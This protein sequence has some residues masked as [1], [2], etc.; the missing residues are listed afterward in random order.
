MFSYAQD[1]HANKSKNDQQKEE[2]V[3]WFADLVYKMLTVMP[4]GRITAVDA[5]AHPFLTMVHFIKYPS[6][7]MTKRNAGMMQKCKINL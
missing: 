2:D 1:L 3:A 5:L 4:S 6:S 7:T